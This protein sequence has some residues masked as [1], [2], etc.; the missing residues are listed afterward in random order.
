VA[1]WEATAGRNLKGES[2]WAH[3]A[4]CSTG[5]EGPGVL[6]NAGWSK[7]P[8]APDWKGGKVSGT[9]APDSKRLVRL[10]SDRALGTGL[11][12][13]Q[14]PQLEVI[15][16]NHFGYAIQWFLFAGIAALIYGLAFRRRRALADANA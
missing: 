13:S 1:G 5:A 6:V 9:I 15:P 10:V 3:L 2:G 11:E 8:D 16:N 14:P 7:S 4:Q 12:I